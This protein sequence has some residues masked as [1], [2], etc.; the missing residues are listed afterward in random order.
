MTNAELYQDGLRRFKACFGVDP[1]TAAYA[2]GRIEVLGNHT[3]YNEG[4]VLSA[5]IDLGVFFLVAPAA[6]GVCR[7]VAADLDEDDRF[8]ASAFGPVAGKSWCN[9]V[10]GVFN[11][12]RQH[13]RI[14]Y[15][16]QALF[17][18]SVPQGAGLGSS[19]ALEM[20]AGLALCSLYGIELEPL[21]LVRIGQNAEHQ[22]V[23]VRCGLLDQI[24]SL[25][26]R[27]ASLILT[28]FRTLEVECVPLGSELVFVVCNTNVKHAL[29]DG[30]YNARRAKC[31][32]AAA[33]FALVLDHPVRSL[34]DVSP[35]EWRQ[36]APQMDAIAARRAIH[37]IG[38]NERV[39]EGRSCLL[40]GDLERFGCLMF[41]S[42]ESSHANFENS[43]P[44]LDFLVRTAGRLPNVIG[45]RLSGGG[46]G[47]SV[48]VLV[49]QRDV[50]TVSQRLTVAY[51]EKFGV[52]CDMRAV[53]PSDGGR[54][55]AEGV[56]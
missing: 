9:Y 22:F 49:R 40:K 23:G 4:F 15:G 39:R 50:A 47:G 32:E 30:E 36:Y 42:H 12:L 41:E 5:A 31:E 56:L 51:R 34:R 43:C 2:P 6:D 52:P 18:G 27:G 13:A 21:T 16:F 44:E 37:V 19:A 38:E 20:A 17:N 25:F 11:G 10:R 35:S 1:V 45:A 28:D 24:S 7:V 55:I 46:F 26:G 33:F 29:V 53:V 3:D 8:E 54:V 14:R 48:I